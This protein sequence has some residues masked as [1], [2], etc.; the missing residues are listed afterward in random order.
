MRKDS[1][2]KGT[3]VL[4]AAALTARALGLFQRVPLDYVLDRV[5]GS[6]FGLANNL[7][8]LLLVVATAGVPSALSKMVSE[9]L[10]WGREEEAARIYRAALAFGLG[11]GIVMTA[12]LYI[13]A[14]W[15]ARLADVP[16]AAAAIRAIAPS[17]LLFPVIAMMRGY[18]QGHRLMTAGAVSQIAEQVARVAVALAAAFALYAA[19]AGQE[20]IAAGA[21]FGTF[22]GSVAAF[23]VMLAWSRRLHGYKRKAGR[24]AAGGPSAGMADAD[25]MSAVSTSGPPA[26]LGPSGVPAAAG[27]AAGGGPPVLVRKRDIYRALFG[28]SVPI[29]LTAMTVQ[30]LYLIDATT[31]IPLAKGAFGRETAQAWLDVLQIRAQ[32]LAGI[33]PILAIALSQSVIPVVAAAY[34]S[35]DAERLRGQ[36]SLALR[37]ALFTGLPVVAAMATLSR[38][39][40]G[41]LF[42]DDAGSWIV[43]WLVASSLFQ[44][45][46][47]T[48][49][50]ILQGMDRVRA[51]MRHTLS[52]VALK[53]VLSLALTPF[54]GVGGL[55][56]ATTVCFVF[57]TVWN[58]AVIRRLAQVRPLGG[59]EGSFA[60]VAAVLVGI[61]AAAAWAMPLA[62]GGLGGKWPYLLT[63]LAGGSAVFLA[64][65]L[66]LVVF[67]VIRPADLASYPRPLAMALAP[68]MRLS[69]ER[70]GRRDKREAKQP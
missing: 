41:L 35:G 28:V 45:T 51:A 65:P 50:A 7:Y 25:G 48:S 8:L 66:L 19:G 21:A 64:Y 43:G 40:T 55:L 49:N 70:D 38:A 27:A 31:L 22:A 30:A 62:V 47:M 10:E 67:R 6:A 4:A 13:A 11:A 63:A 58:F 2:I 36:A 56:A 39:I 61:G 3:I 14:P 32:S 69:G 33:P 42:E 17:L 24:A 53:L 9:R 15:Y 23:A 1:L 5:G 60:A 16:E 12:G 29:L 18:F 54:F 59:R 46:M 44:I 20:Q 26:G 37:I 57:V 52:G 68:F 34:A